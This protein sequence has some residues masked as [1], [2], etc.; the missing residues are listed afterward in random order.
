MHCSIP[1]KYISGGN[2]SQSSNTCGH[3]IPLHN[4]SDL[5]EKL[6]YGHYLPHRNAVRIKEISEKNDLSFFGKDVINMR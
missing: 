3:L 4:H 1:G 2:E 6:L 5:V